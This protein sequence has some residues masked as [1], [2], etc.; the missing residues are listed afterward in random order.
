M[1]DE[2][3][4]LAQ[5]TGGRIIEKIALGW[6]APARRRSRSSHR[7]CSQPRRRMHMGLQNVVLYSKD[8]K[9]K[10]GKE[11]TAAWG[12]PSLCRDTPRAHC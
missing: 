7:D 1:A 8:K 6:L 3:Q 10:R 9:G 2:R 4:D 11:L 12:R 5:R